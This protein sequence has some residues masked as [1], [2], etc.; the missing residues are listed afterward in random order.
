MKEL[1]NYQSVP[2]NKSK[3][4]ICN[5]IEIKDKTLEVILK[6]DLVSTI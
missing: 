4:G 5:I 6:G 3:F 1:E 2:Q